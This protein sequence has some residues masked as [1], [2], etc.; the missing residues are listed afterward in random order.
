[1][2]S[3]A[4]YNEENEQLT[5]FA[6]NRHLKEGLELECDIRNFEGYEV[7]EHIVLENDDLKQT[8]SAKGTPVAPHSN[9]NAAIENGLVSTLLPKLSWNVIR[10]AKR[11]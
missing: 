8:N 4:V 5:I 9:G 2:E 1:M 3:A 10:L 6:V 7:V 11:K